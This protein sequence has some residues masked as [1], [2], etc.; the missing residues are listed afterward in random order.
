VRFY[1]S[2]PSSSLLFLVSGGLLLS[3]SRH[4]SGNGSL[5]NGRRR[6]TAVTATNVSTRAQLFWL[7]V[8]NDAHKVEAL[9]LDPRGCDSGDGSSVSHVRVDADEYVAVGCTST[10]DLDVPRWH[11]VAVATAA[12]QL[13]EVADG[14]IVDDDS[15][16]AVVLDD[17]VLG[18]SGTAAVDGGRLVV[19]LLLDGEGVFADGFPPDIGDGAAALAVDALDLVGACNSVSVCVSCYWASEVQENITHR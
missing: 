8:A 3:R 17:L 15:T 5:D 12:V 10:T 9:V 18:T 16:S 11:L 13:A 4:R 6:G 7:P 19:T 2:S 1:S 14:E